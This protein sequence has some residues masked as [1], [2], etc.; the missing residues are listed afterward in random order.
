MRARTAAAADRTARAH[1]GAVD[2]DG[3]GFPDIID[4]FPTDPTEWIDS[5]HDDIG[6]NADPDDDNDGIP[7][8]V[9]PFPLRSAESARRS[10][11]SERGIR[12]DADRVHA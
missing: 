1:F 7:D 2:S 12:A 8:A 3:D 11:G 5:D 9:D 6:N 10:G 4:D